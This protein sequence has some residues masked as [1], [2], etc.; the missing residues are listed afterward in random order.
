MKKQI[1]KCVKMLFLG[2]IMCLGMALS[3]HAEG[4][5]QFFQFDGEKWN[6]EEFSWTDSQ[7]QIWYAHEYGTNGEAIISAVTEA[8][9]E[10]QVP[11]YVYKNGVAKKVIGIGSYRP[12]AEYD[13]TWARFGCFYYDGKNSDYMLYKVI[14][15][16]TLCYVAPY[17]FSTDNRFGG[18]KDAFDG[19]AAVQLPQNPRLVIGESAFYGDKN[20]QIVHFNDAVGGAQPVK[21]ENKAFGNCP[22]LEEITFPP[23]GAYN[24]I[25][26][27]AFYSYGE[28]CNLKR[29]YNAPSELELG[30]DQYC[31]GVEE[32]SFAEGLTYVGG[33]ST[34]VAYEWNEDGSPSHGQGE[35]IKTLKKVTLP[36]TL[37]E[38]GWDAFKDNKNLTYINLPEGLTTIG[39]YAFAGCTALTGFTSLPAS[40]SGGI[41]EGAF[42]GCKNLHL[43]NVYIHGTDS[44]KYQFTDSG[45]VSIRIGADVTYTVG[46]MFKGCTSL[47]EITVDAGHP[48]LSSQ[49]G[50]LY[51]KVY[52]SSGGE[53]A[54]RSIFTYPA[55]KSWAG[56]YTLPSD[57]V[58]LGGFAFD[59]CKFT[60]IHIP[61]RVLDLDY[62]SMASLGDTNTYYAFDS[63]KDS[64]K[65]YVVKNSYVD[66]YFNTR[67]HFYYENGDVLPISYDLAG[68]TNDSSNPSTFTGGNSIELKAPTRS[69]YTFT[70]WTP[71]DADDE[72]VNFSGSYTPS[73]GELVSGVKLTANWKKNPDP[74]KA[75]EPTKAPTAEPTKAPNAE[76]T[77]A[78]SAPEPTKAP[79][80]S[81][82]NQNTVIPSKLPKLTG[83][84]VTNVLTDGAKISWKRIASATGYQITI[85]TDKKFKKNVKN[86]IV[87]ENKNNELI[88]GLKS[89]KTYYVKV[90][91]IAQGGGKKV[92]G[93]YSKAVKFTIYVVPKV[94]KISVKNN[95]KGTITI[96]ASKVKGA[97]GYAFVVTADSGLTDIVAIKESKKNTVTIKNLSKGHTYYIRACAY[98][99]NKQKQKVFGVYTKKAKIT[100]KK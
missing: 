62:D 40:V 25:D 16:D 80:A 91:A 50:V 4:S 6:K 31:A 29:I 42:R 30:W 97:A 35:Y 99:L 47:K 44:L 61:A 20:L 86:Y 75:P 88:Y 1:S 51:S 89:G 92:T 77:K 60:E 69:G 41:G 21:I 66:N 45:I 14:L 48:Y 67:Y 15:P 46:A 56:S 43:E 85:S 79:N 57:V 53:V 34:I 76:P 73:M 36:S 37:K 19:L 49:D 81:D 11:S 71:V 9:M 33:I 18:G 3:V 22:K 65:L 83:T 32:V 52:K 26:K 94:K 28:C 8:V 70:G 7:G 95:K 59:S 63:I 72:E 64:C 90:R 27:E 2:I 93:K 13:Y 38:I 68:G 24:E 39:S 78:P 82:N 17:A 96:T 5:G 87:E 12:D 100:I 55:G 98:K 23:T 54:G 84:K 74:T 58:L 10:L